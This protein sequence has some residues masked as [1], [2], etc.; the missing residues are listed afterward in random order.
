M[1]GEGE[2]SATSEDGVRSMALALA[3][4]EA[5]RTG[6]RTPVAPGLEG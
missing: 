4:L 5:A 1:R 3:V 6:Q 2:P